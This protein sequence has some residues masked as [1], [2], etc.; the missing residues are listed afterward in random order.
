MDAYLEMPYVAYVEYG[1]T[2][3]IEGNY[4]NVTI[5]GENCCGEVFPM[6]R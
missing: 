6:L 1:G 3:K 5:D 4:L 2:L